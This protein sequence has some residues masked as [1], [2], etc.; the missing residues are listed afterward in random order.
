MND[1][2]SNLKYL[3]GLWLFLII[4][5]IFTYAHHGHLILDCG[6]E[7]YYPQQVL[8]GEI[9][10]KDLFV[11]Y[12]PFSYLFNALMYKFFGANLNTLYLSGC[13]CAFLTIT[14]L[15]FLGTK[16]FSRILSF[17]I[18]SVVISVGVLNL[19]L[20]NFIFPYSYAMLYGI[21]SFFVSVFYLLEF[22]Q[23]QEKPIYFYTACFFAGL[24]I[25]NK[26]E[27]L[28]YL[29]VIFYSMFNVRKFRQ[30]EYFYSLFA[31][32]SIPVLCF[33]LL[34]LQG[35]TFQDM[36]LNFSVLQKMSKS[37]TLK[38]FYST[39]GVYF[40]VKTI[41]FLLGAF[42]KTVV[43]F[44]LLYFSF[45][46]NKKIPA[47]IMKVVAVISIIFSLNPTSFA[48][49]PVLVLI[50]LI[51]EFK[52]VTK[53]ITLLLLTFS[54]VSV[55]L[56][57]FWGLALF[58]YG[59]FFSGYLFI[60]F[61]ALILN[62]S[63]GKQLNQN[64]IAI[65]FLIAALVFGFQNASKISIKQNSINTDK[66]GLFVSNSLHKS[67]DELVKYIQTQTKQDDS[68]LI[69]PEGLMIN[70]LAGRKSDGYY[71]SM[72]PLYVEVFS[73]EAFIDHFKKTKPDYIVFNNWRSQ[74]YYFNYICNDYAQAF[75]SFVA[76]N[77]KQEKVVD[78]GFRYLIFR[79]N[80]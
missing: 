1:I 73:D 3:T 44:L 38:Y 60:S 31:L 5:T 22:S 32:F 56:K 18:C 80:N 71:N 27:F 64:V 51:K 9:L 75:C 72:I 2:K 45:K 62:S 41:P 26:Y 35:L 37:Q 17:S 12:G 67:T 50:I 8:A 47:F 40:N 34:F 79:R 53:N 42:L 49:I 78:D 29:F 25:A 11:I 46:I 39:Q 43:P 28:P 77:Y 52:H 4:S 30:A 58:N 6:R 57:V 14:V 69:F 23:K 48:F 66:G 20:F 13:I 21:L 15:Y 10:Y 55:M 61:W 7:A 24:C 63:K 16:F 33:S 76:Q 65:Y 70:F 54:A 59:I 68:I 19:H 74:D 36:S